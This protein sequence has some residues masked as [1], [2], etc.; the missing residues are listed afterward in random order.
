MNASYDVST[1]VAP[2]LAAKLA[3]L[4]KKASKL[5]QTLSWSEHHQNSGV[6]FIIDG[7]QPKLA[8]WSFF[9]VLEHSDGQPNVVKFIQPGIGTIHQNNAQ[10][11]LYSGPDCN[12]CKIKRKRNDTFLVIDNTQHIKQVGR[13]CLK[14]FLGHANPHDVAKYADLLAEVYAVSKA[15]E[16]EVNTTIDLGKGI[17]AATH[18]GSKW[19][20]NSTAYVDTFIYL[21]NVAAAMRVGKFVSVVKAE[22][23][24]GVPTWQT[25]FTNMFGDSHTNDVW[26]DDDELAYAALDWIERVEPTNSF[27]AKLKSICGTGLTAFQVSQAPIVGA[28]IVTYQ[29]ELK[30]AIDLEFNKDANGHWFN[31][32]DHVTLE[33]KVK[34][35]KPFVTKYNSKPGI[36]YILKDTKSNHEF[37]TF[38][39]GTATKLN[40]G[41][42][43]TLEGTIH[44][45]VYN[46]VNE[47]QIKSPVVITSETITDAFK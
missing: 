28:L 9:A 42:E 7:S 15:A 29:N 32:G 2:I 39:N 12:H 5:N 4:S 30:K 22:S 43:I 19:H 11:W 17:V 27:V 45:A 44:H 46:G 24:G 25:A 18:A 3:V 40:L 36:L 35:A 33:L 47:T 13:N 8:G 26:L 14:D 23:S 34:T 1:A 31:E 21:Q 38:A 16:D 6:R 37:K 41:Q 10:G 20:S